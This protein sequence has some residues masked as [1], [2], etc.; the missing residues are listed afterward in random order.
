MSF[1]CDFSSRAEG[2][3]NTW[4]M[5]TFILP[6]LTCKSEK[7]HFQH[8]WNLQ[9]TACM[10]SICR[11]LPMNLNL[12]DELKTNQQLHITAQLTSKWNAIAAC[13]PNQLCDLLLHAEMPPGDNRIGI[14][15]FPW[16][17]KGQRSKFY[18]VSFLIVHDFGWSWKIRT[19]LHYGVQCLYMMLHLTAISDWEQNPNR[20][21]ATSI[22]L[23]WPMWL[24][25]VS[26]DI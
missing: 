23:L 3:L 17:I 12:I 10:R 9:Q 2:T 14:N 21:F 20:A 1:L 24:S 7:F 11:R 4:Y 5:H 26:Q 18:I 8:A 6:F 22:R 15:V 25:L 16:E 13:L 19:W